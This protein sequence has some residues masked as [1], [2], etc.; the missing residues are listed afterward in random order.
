MCLQGCSKQGSQVIVQ[1]ADSCETCGTTTLNIP[2][3]T[4]E[5]YLGPPSSGNLGILYQQVRQSGRLS[6]CS[7]CSECADLMTAQTALHLN[8]LGVQCTTALP[9]LNDV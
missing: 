3:K 5:N 8:C 4:F 1:V 7:R 6:W 2:Y 9:A